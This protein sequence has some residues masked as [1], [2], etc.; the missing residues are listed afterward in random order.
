[1]KVVHLQMFKTLLHSSLLYDKLDISHRH[2]H[3]SIMLIKIL[4]YLLYINDVDKVL[5]IYVIFNY[6]NYK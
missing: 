1:V 2:M 3:C 5:H 4:F 6:K